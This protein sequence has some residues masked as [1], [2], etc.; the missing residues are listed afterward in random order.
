MLPEL[1]LLIVK[2]RGRIIPARVRER[3][4]LYVCKKS[5]QIS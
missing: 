2:L 4:G 1:R 5:Y 3:S